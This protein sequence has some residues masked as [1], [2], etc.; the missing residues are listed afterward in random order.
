LT[1]FA[2]KSI[3]ELNIGKVV[4]RDTDSCGVML[5]KDSIMNIYK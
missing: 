1:Y 2:R 3:E 5:S 4:F